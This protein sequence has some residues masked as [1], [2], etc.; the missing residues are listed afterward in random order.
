MATKRMEPRECPDCGAAV[1]PRGL[2]GHRRL[3]HGAVGKPGPEAADPE[4]R[5][6]Q[7]VLEGLGS[8][9]RSI[10]RIEARLIHLEARVE[11]VAGEAREAALAESESER[12]RLQ[13][14]LDHLVQTIAA[15]KAAAAEEAARRGRPARTDEELLQETAFH[16]RL[17]RLNRRRYSLLFRLS[18]GTKGGGPDFSSFG[19]V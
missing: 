4:P 11:E 17:G 13:R 10:W 6:S 2:A 19:V 8:I 9:E 14:E 3:A 16:Q 12:Q 7:A 18:E 15:E 5:A 1:D